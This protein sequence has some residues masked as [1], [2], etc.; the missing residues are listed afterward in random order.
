MNGGAP[1]VHFRNDQEA[2]DSIVKMANSWY[3]T[4]RKVL[5]LVSA[6]PSATP[7]VGQM[8]TTVNVDT[9]HASTVNTVV[10]EIAVQMRRGLDLPVAVAE[11]SLTTAVGELD[12]LVFFP[13]QERLT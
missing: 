9:A 3:G 7:L 6:R 10:S 5:R 12:P 11:Y 8:V 2:L 13:R 4:T 1:V